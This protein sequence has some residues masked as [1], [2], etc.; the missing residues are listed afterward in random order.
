MLDTALN[1]FGILFGLVKWPLIAFA[2]LVAFYILDCL[3]WYTLRYIKGSRVNRGSVRPLPRRSIFLKLFVDA[4]KQY[5]DDLYNLPPDFFRPQGLIVF[6]GRQGAGKSSAMIQYAIDLHDMY[7]M[8]KCISNTSFIY[9]DVPLRHW[10]QL[11]NFTNGQKGV[12][13]IMDELQNWFSSNQSKNF[14]PKMLS[15]ITQNRKNRRVILATAQSFHLLAK[16]I[17]SQCTEI[18]QCITLA[19][20]VTVV[21]RREP[22][23]DNDGDVKQMKYL[24]MYFFVHSPRLRKAYDTWAVVDSL[25]DSGFHDNPLIKDEETVV[26][27]SLKK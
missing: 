23:C 9:Q 14:P 8:S 1:M 21:V 5:I 7:P 24:G 25:A 4:P 20:V 22:V 26:D 11:V 3:F 27:V 15:V 16:A 19:G 6:T 17:R 13:V 12:V 18:R 10:M 2:A